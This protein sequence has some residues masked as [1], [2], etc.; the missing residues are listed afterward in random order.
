MLYQLFLR[1]CAAPTGGGTKKALIRVK[2]YDEAIPGLP[3]E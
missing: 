2:K 1:V 3:R